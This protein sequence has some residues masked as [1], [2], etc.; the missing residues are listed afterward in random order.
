MAT[1]AEIGISMRIGMGSMGLGRGRGNEAVM[2]PVAGGTD[3]KA[4]TGIEMAQHLDGRHAN[5]TW[6]MPRGLV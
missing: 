4:G 1:G 3:V 2:K 5:G 6:E